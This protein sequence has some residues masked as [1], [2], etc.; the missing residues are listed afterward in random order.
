MRSQ[1]DRGDERA[2][3]IVR[4]SRLARMIEVVIVTVIEAWRG[5]LTRRLAQQ[6]IVRA[7]GGT[8]SGRAGVAGAVTVVASATALAL[9]G[10]ASR[11]APLVWIVPALSLVA[12]LCLIGLARVKLERQ[13]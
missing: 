4:S 11:P 5:S 8:P 6:S 12:G 10:F 13:P 9:Q 2:L 7:T 1:E 3:A